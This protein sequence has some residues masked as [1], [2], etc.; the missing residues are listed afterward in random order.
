[1]PSTALLALRFLAGFAVLAVVP[2]F[3]WD[4]LL[5]SGLLAQPGTVAE[6]HEASMLVFAIACGAVAAFALWQPPGSPW[7]PARPARV[8]AVY[9]PFAVVWAGVLVGYLALARGLGA[10]VPPQPA[11]EYLAAGQ[12]G[13]PGF[14]VVCAA[15]AIAGPLAEEIV[16]RGY[17][18]HALATRM[19][20]SFAI[21][22][23]AAAFG[24][25]HTLPYAFPVGLL[26]VLFGTL[27]SRSG[28]LWP[29]V[30]AHMLHNAVTV[31]VTVL[32]PESLTLLYPR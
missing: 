19:R 17:L 23:T 5:R 24:A 13:R 29:A 20:P 10:A 2:Q 22:L 32:W 12:T 14:W 30:L 9:V 15:I 26:G 25:V 7:R 11:L 4:L 28:S 8:V 18:Q 3:A 21:V 1:M 31:A 27:A 6:K 16:F